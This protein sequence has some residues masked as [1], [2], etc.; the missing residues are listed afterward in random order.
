MI[1]AATEPLLGNQD[2]T[3]Q[4]WTAAAVNAAE[5]LEDIAGG[6]SGEVSSGGSSLVPAFVV[7]AVVLVGAFAVFFLV[8]SRSGKR[9][10]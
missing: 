8:R 4:D 5:S 3:S 2:I 9:A 7:A 6:G 10:R 1:D